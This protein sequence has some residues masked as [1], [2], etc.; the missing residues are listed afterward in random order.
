MGLISLK[1]LARFPAAPLS[2]H[3]GSDLPR[4]R[5]CYSPPPTLANAA[6]AASRVASVAVRRGAVLVLP[7]GQRP[8]PGC[9][10]RFRGRLHDAADYDAV[11]QHVVVVVAPLAG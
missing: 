6:I 5:A 10:G 8:Q 3:L 9:V 11:S 2:R 1:P 7:V 4:Q